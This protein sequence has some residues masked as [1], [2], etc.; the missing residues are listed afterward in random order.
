LVK[1]YQL[2]KNT[3]DLR[4]AIAQFLKGMI[5]VITG[6]IVG[7]SF[8]ALRKTPLYFGL[9]TG[10]LGTHMSLAEDAYTN[11][12]PSSGYPPLWPTLIGNIARLSDQD[13]TYAYKTLSILSVP[14]L[15]WINYI[16]FRK[17]FPIVL[18]EI[19]ALITTFSFSNQGWKTAGTIW[20][21]ILIFIL[22]SEIWKQNLSE[23][24]LD[25]KKVSKM[26]LYGVCFGL[27]LALYYGFI[28]WI[29]LSLAAGIIYTA[30]KFRSQSI[31]VYVDSF[32]IGGALV[33]I[34]LVVIK[35]SVLTISEIILASSVITVLFLV[36][37]TKSKIGYV[38]SSVSIFA[39]PIAILISLGEI[40]TGDDYFYPGTFGNMLN[41]GFNGYTNL[42][43]YLIVFLIG[44]SYFLQHNKLLIIQSIFL[45][46]NL[47][48]AN[49]IMLFYA[50][51]M[52]QSKKVELWPRAESV[53]H[54]SLDWMFIISSYGLFRLVIIGLQ[55]NQ[56]DVVFKIENSSGLYLA[57][58][59]LIIYAYLAQSIGTQMW[60]MYPR[61][62]NSTMSSYISIPYIK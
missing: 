58:L 16:L 60:G 17:S 37:L 3:V 4:T 8:V 34:P 29:S 54:L 43:I 47:V 48:S 50:F 13:L 33:L 11:V 57:V 56:R 22:I 31:N 9:I 36:S 20:S 49:I 53:I 39:I 38:A 45:V 10:D 26:M 27:S 46:M 62:E 23:N 1:I 59:A 14:I 15:S 18:A 44:F 6:L 2:S 28:R 52:F 32:F 40:K 24:L 12:I 25:L 19:L 35:M 61:D 21:L 42:F 51:N 30:L 7:T 55:N 41:F 5:V